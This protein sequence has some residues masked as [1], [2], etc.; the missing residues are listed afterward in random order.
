MSDKKQFARYIEEYQ[1]CLNSYY[2]KFFNGENI[3]F[4]NIC[5]EE[6]DKIKTSKFFRGFENEYLNEK[7][8]LD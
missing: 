3:S 1:T 7:K 8:K 6:F 5:E 4:K 2:D